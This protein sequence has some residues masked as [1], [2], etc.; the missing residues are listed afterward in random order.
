[1]HIT[2]TKEMQ[3][4]MKSEPHRYGAVAATIHWLTALAILMLL[5]SGFVAASMAGEVPVNLVRIHV[6]LGLA[7]VLLTLLRI[8]W[9]LAI[10]TRPADIAGT[11]RWQALAARIVHVLLY[12][13]VLLMGASGIGLVVLSNALPAL[14]GAAPLPDFARFPP[15]VVHGLVARIL[16]GL[17]VLHIAAALFHQF[18]RRDRLLARMGLGRAHQPIVTRAAP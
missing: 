12:C 3:M 5:T 17:A 18:V 1:M 6:A 4:A 13:I 7:T 16:I 15:L 2:R 10:D 14:M 9:W 11:P 8:V